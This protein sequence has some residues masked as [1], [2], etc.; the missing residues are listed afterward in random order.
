[1]T[2]TRSRIKA[3]IRRLLWLRQQILKC[4]HLLRSTRTTVTVHA[5]RWEAYAVPLALYLPPHK[6][7]RLNQQSLILP[8]PNSLYLKGRRCPFCA[9]Q[10][11]S[12]NVRTG[13]LR[14][15]ARMAKPVV[16]DR[17]QPITFHRCGDS[18]CFKMC[19]VHFS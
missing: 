6:T 18:I 4:S 7:L 15:A 17:R 5:A 12:L 13:F 8:L 16:C 14:F 19:I 1:M 3:T 10:N 2:D 11:S 9:L